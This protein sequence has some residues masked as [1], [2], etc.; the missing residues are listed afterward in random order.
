MLIHM[1]FQDITKREYQT[2]VGYYAYLELK[3]WCLGPK[4][5]EGESVWDGGLTFVRT[6]ARKWDTRAGAVAH[7]T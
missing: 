1:T 7:V 3:I 4:G 5:R 6:A 2:G